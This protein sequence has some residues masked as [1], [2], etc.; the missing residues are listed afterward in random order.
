MPLEAYTARL[1]VF[2]FGHIMRRYDSLSGTVMLGKVEDNKRRIRRNT[3]QIN[4]TKE[5]T[6]ASLN[7]FSSIAEDKIF[8]KLLIYIVAIG[9]QRLDGT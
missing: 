6:V 7:V 3:R 5:T 4:S 8:W 2:Y 9:Q 1:K